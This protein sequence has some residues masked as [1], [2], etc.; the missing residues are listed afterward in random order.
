MIA[1]TN[2]GKLRTVPCTGLHK[3]MQVG[4]DRAGDDAHANVAQS[5]LVWVEEMHASQHAAAATR[6]AGV[7]QIRHFF[8]TRFVLHAWNRV[9]AA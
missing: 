7:L 2:A 5:L 4:G 3:G 1:Q 9:A 8:T 6:F